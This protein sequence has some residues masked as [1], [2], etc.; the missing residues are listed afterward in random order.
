MITRFL[1]NVLTFISCF[2]WDYSQQTIWSTTC[3]TGMNQSPVDIPDINSLPE[4]QIRYILEYTWYNPT[5]PTRMMDNGHYL[6]VIKY[7]VMYARVIY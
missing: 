2:A 5:S 7:I 1:I 6:I 4:S 3:T